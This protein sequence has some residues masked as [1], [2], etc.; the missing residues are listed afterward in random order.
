MALGAFPAERGPLTGLWLGDNCG[1]S[2]PETLLLD[3]SGGC[4]V[5]SDVGRE[6]AFPR[7]TP[8]G[9]LNWGA[10]G[11]APGGQPVGLVDTDVL[12]ESTREPP[13]QPLELF[14]SGRCYARA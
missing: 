12:R 9:M 13:P 10:V 8:H 4:W 7:A 11:N 1:T 6:D 14:T 2:N 5:A 3:A